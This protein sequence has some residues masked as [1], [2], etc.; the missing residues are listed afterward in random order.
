MGV[1]VTMGMGVQGQRG[2]AP[3][4]TGSNIF[5]EPIVVAWRGWAHACENCFYSQ[6]RSAWD[7]PPTTVWFDATSGGICSD[8]LL[9]DPSQLVLD[10]S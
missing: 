4:S 5:C 7:L 9:T 6:K 10:G 2:M 3:R 8:Q 1:G